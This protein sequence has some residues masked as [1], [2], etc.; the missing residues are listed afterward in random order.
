MEIKDYLRILGRRIRIL[1]LVPLLALAA[2]AGYTLVQPKQYQAVATVAAPALVGGAT[3][4]QYSGAN[5]LKAF[6][7]NFTA[8]VT[9]PRSAK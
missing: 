3:A 6:V 9:S 8:A 5:G 1:I 2:V 4:N 7:G